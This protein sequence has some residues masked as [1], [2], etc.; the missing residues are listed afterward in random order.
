M[1]N[2]NIGKLIEN[3]DNRYALVMDIANRARK[4]SN[5]AEKQEQIL[6]EKPVSIAIDMLAN[7]KGL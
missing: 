2:K 7:E 5:E 3:Y 4:I 6:I 1:L